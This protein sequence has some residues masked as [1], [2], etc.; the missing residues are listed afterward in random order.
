MMRGLLAVLAAAALVAGI[1]V[2]A[3]RPDLSEEEVTAGVGSL[4]EAVV[5]GWESAI[6]RLR[7]GPPGVAGGGDDDGHE[8][9]DEADE[10]LVIVG[11]VPAVRLGEAAQRLAGIETARLEAVSMTPE[12]AAIGAVV[13]IQPLLDLRA[14]YRETYFLAEAAE[15]RLGA[16][17]REHERLNAL[18]QDDAN[19]AMKAVQQA[20]AVWKVEY[21]E[22]SRLWDALGAIRT[23][24]ERQ[25][26]AVLARWAFDGEGEAFERLVRFED[27]LLAVPLPAGFR[28][29][30]EGSV[31]YMAANGERA[32]ARAVRYVS[33][34]PRSARALPG[35]T[36]F[37]LVPGDSLPADMRVQLWLPTAASPLR[38]MALPGSAVVT[39]LGRS[40]AF[41][42]V[43]AEHFVRSAVELSTL[44]PDGR[45]LVDGFGADDEVVVTGAVI[46][47][48]EEFRSQIRDEDED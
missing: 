20:E 45:Y 11:G 4:A 5:G 10:E 44:M 28:L 36:H 32:R 33:P 17:R 41:R 16:A 23:R 18:Y 29:P 26:G 24:A 2:V 34:S 9:D 39:A 27:S 43:D 8:E 40:W 6:S 14:D 47:L 22:R 21:A 31:A 19:V 7:G 37:F 35:E 46:L 12:L 1:A 48:A 25:W 42:R 30:G 15:I 38:G 3:G 13:D